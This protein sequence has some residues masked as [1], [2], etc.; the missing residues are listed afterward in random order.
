MTNRRQFILSTTA[1]G[2][3]LVRNALDQAQ[4]PHGAVDLSPEQPGRIRVPKNPAAIAAI[5][6]HYRFVKDGDLL[7][8]GR[9]DVV[10][11]PNAPLAYDSATTGAIRE[12]GTLNAGWPARADVAIATRK[13][14][15]L[16][17]ALTVATNG[18]IADGAYQRSLAR[19][20]IESE[21]LARS[22]SNPPGL[23][24]F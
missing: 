7:L 6:N 10:F 4:A 14:S 8:S 23:P 24:K 11:N 17:D 12:V 16:M 3:L 15:G 20:G 13:G 21:A 9:A 19:W 18:L 2:A 22:Q 5:G 1:L